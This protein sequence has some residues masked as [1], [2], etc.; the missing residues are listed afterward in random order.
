VGDGD[1]DG[2]VA[3]VAAGQPATAGVGGGG[4]GSDDDSNDDDDDEQDGGGPV[5]LYA[6]DKKQRR[7]VP[8]GDQGVHGAASD[9]AAAGH[10]GG[11]AGS[12]ATAAHGLVISHDA[13]AAQFE[14]R[15][16]ASSG[17]VLAYLQYTLSPTERVVDFC[18]TFTAP[19]ARGV[20][21]AAQV[22]DAAMAWAK[23]GGLRVVPSCTYVHGPYLQR[24][25]ARTLPELAPGPWAKASGD[26]AAK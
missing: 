13:A 21:L 25:D 17:P 11:P 2:M 9:A 12:S 5:L 26:A 7:G 15:A 1:G 22:T 14:A 19:E 23:A 10:S 6:R 24:A 18:H 8:A 20:G 4:G 3:A 16:G